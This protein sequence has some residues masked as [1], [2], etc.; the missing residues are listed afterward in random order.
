MAAEIRMNLANT[1]T[2]LEQSAGNRQKKG[3]VRDDESTIVTAPQQ[4]LK[5]SNIFVTKRRRAKILGFGLAKIGAPTQ[6]VTQAAKASK[7]CPASTFSRSS[8]EQMTSFW[9]GMSR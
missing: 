8:R 1:L 2:E 7:R 6:S 5:R 4:I 9:Y 3:L